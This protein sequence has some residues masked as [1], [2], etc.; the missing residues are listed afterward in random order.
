MRY[1]AI[2]FLVIILTLASVHLAEAQQATKVPRIGFLSAL[3]PEGVLTWVEAFRQG[4][5]ELGY[6]EG[7]NVVVEW[8]Y[9]E[10]KLDRLPSLAN[11]LV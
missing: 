11:E 7:N 9:A 8:R 5:R 10:A 6:V 2:V 3:S 4:L 1:K